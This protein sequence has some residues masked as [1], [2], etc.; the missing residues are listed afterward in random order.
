MKTNR[1]AAL[2]IIG[3]LVAAVSGC[4]TSPMSK[5]MRAEAKSNRKVTVAT[6]SKSP[7]AFVG[8]EVIWGGE[9][10][11]VVNETNGS[12]IYL[13]EIALGPGGA[14]VY[15]IKSRG[16]FIAKSS[17]TLDPASYQPGRVITL[18]GKISGQ[19][20]DAADPTAPKY[21][22]V[23][24]QEIHFWKLQ[25][26]ASRDALFE[27]TLHDQYSPTGPEPYPT[28]GQELYFSPD[29]RLDQQANRSLEQSQDIRQALHRQ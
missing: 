5:S 9:I 26:R 21:P 20:T 8:T 16:I 29:T 13:S 17:G 22:L 12:E 1:I 3:G 6:V 19:E 28:I 2:L 18:G 4:A 10:L 27:P 23:T 15:P 14:P 11:K 24:M 7:S 25:S